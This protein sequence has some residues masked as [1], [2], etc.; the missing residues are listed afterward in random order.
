MIS[1]SKHETFVGVAEQNQFFHSKRERFQYFYF[2]N[3]CCIINN[4]NWDFVFP[5]VAKM[6]FFY[7]SFFNIKYKND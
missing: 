6:R 4:A 7:N 2:W 3:L 1:I 5:P